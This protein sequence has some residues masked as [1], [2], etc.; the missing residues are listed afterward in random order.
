MMFMS[1]NVRTSRNW[2]DADGA[3]IYTISIDHDAVDHAAFL[4]RMVEVKASRRVSWPETAHFPI[5]HCGI[6][7]RYLILAW[8]GNDNEL[9]TSVSALT[10]SGWVERPE[11]YSF[12]V[13]DLEVFWEE[14]NIYIDTM[15]GGHADI[16]AYRSARRQD[17][18]SPSI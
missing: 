5:F 3:K 13:H 8:W 2:L 11:R 15:L 1:R 6:T 10:E 14:R 16:H 17:W 18:L 4:A 9:F 7:F 12:C